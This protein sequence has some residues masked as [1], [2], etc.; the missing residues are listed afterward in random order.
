MWFHY[1]FM[2]HKFHAELIKL[3]LCKIGPF[4]YIELLVI[5]VPNY[6]FLIHPHILN[7]IKMWP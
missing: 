3:I 5:L 1:A 6:E 4:I 2:D 7:S